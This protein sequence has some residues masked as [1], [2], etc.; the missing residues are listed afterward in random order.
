MIL[1]NTLQ[2]TPIDATAPGNADVGDL[3]RF[4]GTQY[5]FNWSTQPFST[6]TWQMQAQLDDGTVHTVVVGLK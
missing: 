4:D 2:G 5:I 1:G 3:F 6:G